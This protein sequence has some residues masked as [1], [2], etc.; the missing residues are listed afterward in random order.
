VGAEIRRLYFV[1]RLSIKEI[2][3]RAGHAR[4]A[5]RRALCLPEAPRYRRPP[6]PS[7]LD[8]PGRSAA[9]A[10]ERPAAAG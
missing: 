10:A 9:A 3:R 5:V 1:K 2:V 7:K 8:A 4:N 6:R